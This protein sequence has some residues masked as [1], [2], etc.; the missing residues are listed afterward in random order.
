MPLDNVT[1]LCFFASYLAALLLELSQFARPSPV[2]RWAAIGFTAAGL[3]AH[4]IYLLVRSRNSQLPPLLSSTHDW[5][6]VLSWLA[7]VMDLAVVLWDRRLALGLF[8]LPPVVVMVG[9][10]RF[11]SQQ[12]EML[13]GD[14]YWLSMVHASCLVL[15]MA[16]VFACLVLSGMYLA[17]HRRLK[18]KQ[19][20][21][22]ELQL[23]SLERLSRWNWWAVIVSVPVLTIGMALGLVLSYRSQGTASPVPLT[24]AGFGVTG[25]VWLRMA[26]LF[27]WL[28]TSRK[29]G[30]RIVAWRT[31]W[32]CGLLLVTLLVLQIFTRGGVHGT[33]EKSEG[34]S[35]K[36]EVVRRLTRYGSSNF[37]LHSSLFTLQSWREGAAS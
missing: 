33:A 16:G 18:S 11:V 29:P 5:L 22:E 6:L 4:T 35:V 12:P 2:A 13:Q 3:L 31:V 14:L 10:A 17:Q 32:A 8:V 9:A 25:I 26:V 37:T 28:L 7:V 20:G 36:S 30:G 19:S 23:F 27:G 34:R 1:L 15:G 24:Q 21:G